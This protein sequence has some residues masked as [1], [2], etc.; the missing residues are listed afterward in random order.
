MTA[1]S[2]KV[3]AEIDDLLE[4]DGS[5]LG[6]V[7]RLTNEGLDPEAIAARLGVRTSAFVH[8]Y[9]QIA[10]CLREGT[11]PPA[12][13]FR[14]D[15]AR[16]ALKQSRAEGLSSDARRHLVGLSEEAKQALEVAK[17]LRQQVDD[18]L[19]QR[20][21]ELLARIIAESDVSPDD[22]QWV[23][24]SDVVLDALW[25]FAHLSH[26]SATTRTLIAA[27]RADLT[28]E[29]AIQA[30]AADLPIPDVTTASARGRLEFW[31]SR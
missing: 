13:S 2:A 6:D 23:A 27:A 22:Y 20:I 17:S 16:I 29:A 31:E 21:G 9:R 30:W 8:N 26:T 18:S 3:I 11:V 28:L 25:T 24:G 12:R 14:K 1:P 5:R 10:R 19:R 15:V 7:Y 4:A